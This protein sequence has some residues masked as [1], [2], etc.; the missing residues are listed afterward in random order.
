M[1]VSTAAELLSFMVASYNDGIPQEDWLKESEALEYFRISQ[2]ELNKVNGTGPW[3]KES[4]GYVDGVASG[5]CFCPDWVA[6]GHPE[7]EGDDVELPSRSVVVY[8]DLLIVAVSA[9]GQI[10]FEWACWCLVK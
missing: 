6:L 9:P 4:Y 8:D 1:H 2:E 5:D 7:L 10:G 3:T